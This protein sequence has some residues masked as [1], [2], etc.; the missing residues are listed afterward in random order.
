MR[1]VNQNFETITAYDPTAGRLVHTT[2]IR[3]DASPID[4]VTKFAWAEEDYE[5]V[6]MYVSNPVKTI[7][8]QVTELKAQLAATD[9]KVI[10]CSECQLLGMEMPYD[11][12]AL[13]AQ[14]QAIRDQ[15]NALEMEVAD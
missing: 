5:D 1:V 4:N 11:V 6:L 12:A 10:K 14:R 8:Q 9:Y 15:I 2:V 7:T 3:A 13:H